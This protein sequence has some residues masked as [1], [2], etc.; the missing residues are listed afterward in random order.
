MSS[1]DHPSGTDSESTV[2]LTA[3]FSETA[4]ALFAAGSAANTLGQVV[5]SAVDTIDGCD[6]AGIFL[7]GGDQGA[8]SVHTDPAAAAADALE[9]DA[10]EGPCL[11]AVNE[12]GSVY[13]EDLAEDRRWPSF[14]PSASE[15]G[16][17]SMVSIRLQGDRTLGALNLY[18]RLP[19]AF[20]LIDRAKGL[21]LAALAGIAVSSAQAHE[22]EVRQLDNLTQALATREVIGQAQGILMERERVTAG[23]AFDILRR[24]SQHLNVKL[25][26]VAQSLVDTGEQPSSPKTQ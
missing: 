6:F 19:R 5:S 1:P 20:G 8:S 17:R 12:G 23:E 14:G 18:A 13:A 26:D 15:A 3:N 16:I 10:G 21:V 24:A 7:L 22:A 25:R 4:R 2:E 11:D 9:R